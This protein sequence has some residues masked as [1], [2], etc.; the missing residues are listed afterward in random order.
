MLSRQQ[1][2]VITRIDRETGFRSTIVGGHDHKA[3]PAGT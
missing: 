3:D 1:L 2:R